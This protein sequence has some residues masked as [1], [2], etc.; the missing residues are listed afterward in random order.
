MNLYSQIKNK[1]TL[2][3]TQNEGMWHMKSIGFNIT[4]SQS[5]FNPFSHG[6]TED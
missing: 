5:D 6:Y 2:I 3:L 4:T 1:N